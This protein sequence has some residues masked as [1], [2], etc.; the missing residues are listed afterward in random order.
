MNK[1]I[2]CLDVETNG[3]GGFRPPQ[4]RVMQISWIFKD[5]EYNYF[6]NDVE[7]VSPEVP[8]DLSISFCK[9]SG[10]SWDYVYNIFHNHLEDSDI[11]VCHNTAF[12][13]GSVAYELKIRKHKKYKA[14]KAILKDLLKSDDIFCTMLNSIDICKIKFPDNNGYKYPKLEE[15][16]KHLFN[17][18]PDEFGDLHDALVDCKVL[19]L[20][21]DEIIK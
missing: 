9:E 18:T 12:D 16:Y 6:I 7:A 13:L 21:Y 19:K 2:L 17:K 4:Q 3:Y 10:V 15:L 8:H 1:N 14:Y 5:N 11:V 20:C